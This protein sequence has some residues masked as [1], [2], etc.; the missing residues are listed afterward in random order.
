MNNSGWKWYPTATVSLKINFIYLYG[1]F[2]FLVATT[3]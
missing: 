3:G 1:D 2:M